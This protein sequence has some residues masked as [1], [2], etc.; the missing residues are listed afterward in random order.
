MAKKYRKNSSAHFLPGI[1]SEYITWDGDDSQRAKAFKQFN[2][3][4]QNFNGV[5]R[6][7]ALSQDYSN[8]D[9]RVSGRPGLRWSDYDAFR[10]GEARPHT[11]RDIILETDRIYHK[12]GIVR[13]IFDLMSDFS[14]Q[15]IRLVH[16][17]KRIEQFH[18]NWWK[19]VGGDYVSERFFS[20]LY[21]H[22]N[23][24]MRK[25]Y[26]KV[27]LRAE[28]DLYKSMAQVETEIDVKNPKSR[29]IPWIYTFL[30]P[31]NVIIVGGALASFAG[32]KIYGLKLP[33]EYKKIINSP[34]NDAEREIVAQLPREI[35]E[36][37]KTNKP[38]VLPADK[39][40][41][42]HY[43]KDDWQDWGVPMLYSIMED[44]KTLEKLKL[45]DRAALDGAISN[46]RIWKLGSLEHKLPPNPAA[47]YRLSE[48][49]EN[50]TGAG[51]MDVV[52]DAAIDL[53]ESKSTVHQF[54]GEEKY[55][56]TMNNIYAGLGIP[57]T[58]TGT[59]GAAGTTNNFISLKTL[60]QRLEYGRDVLRRFWEAELVELQKAMGFRFPARLE[61]DQT[62]LADEDA[63]KSLLIQLADRNLISDELLQEK[64]N[65]EPKMEK[66]RLNRELRERESGRMVPKSG[67][68]HD[69]Q[70]GV[71]LKKIALQSGVVTPT[72]VGIRKDQIRQDLKLYEKEEKSE[73]NALEFR[74]A[75]SPGST[76]PAAKKGQSGQ[77]RQKGQKDSAP[78]K[79]K[80]FT[81][82]S[83]AVTEAWANIAQEH[84]SEF[85][86]EPI[87]NMYGKK[88]LRSL[89]AEQAK[90]AEMLKFGVLFNLEPLQKVDEEDIAKAL[91]K[92]LPSYAKQTHKNICTHLSAAL[93]KTLTNDEIRQV[94]ST[95]Y[96]IYKG[97][98]DV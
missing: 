70:F 92:P 19:R 47:A 8:L 14:C 80:K 10:P 37:A 40:L 16:P 79:T 38:I 51:T 49:L 81:P 5:F 3:A 7:E 88:N 78:R 61:F 48:I 2:E 21:R 54:L 34:R 1:T 97:E 17:N 69:P 84:I 95:I 50:N 9:T 64:F 94:Q 18:R 15:G 39:T 63:I 91:A 43:K 71:A 35:K 24:V 86:R 76:K 67:A 26:A 90:E 73:K 66:I 42:F 60:T 46:I 96:A 6:S 56:P 87:L 32:K 75:P 23:V 53:L 89:S 62:N 30:H 28:Q 36:A 77:G 11:I 12:E 25:Q 4:L 57:P 83:K 29:E 20:Y 44:L 68:F 74:A 41:V 55:K 58:L 72:Q 33:G 98:E 85:L 45:A 31:S 93:N 82:K 22:A 59:F 27:S 65:I 52:W 13:N